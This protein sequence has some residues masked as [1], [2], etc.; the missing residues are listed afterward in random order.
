MTF[1]GVGLV[2]KSGHAENSCWK[3]GASFVCGP[4]GAN[5]ECWCDALPAVSPVG[6]N[7]TC[8]CPACLRLAYKL[9]ESASEPD[10]SPSDVEPRNSLLKGEDYYQDGPYVV[11]TAAYLRRRGYCCKNGCRNCPY[12]GDAETPK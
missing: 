5:A 3:C 8:M 6:G 7:T 2:P 1:V 9:I 4:V 10:A 12:P 11:F